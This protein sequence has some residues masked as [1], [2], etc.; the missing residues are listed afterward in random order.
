M[1][2]STFFAA[3]FFL[4]L[5]LNK[6]NKNL[7][8]VLQLFSVVGTFASNSQ[9]HVTN[10]TYIC[11]SLHV[12]FAR[13]VPVPVHAFRELVLFSLN[14]PGKGGGSHANKEG[15]SSY[16]LGVE[17]PGFGTAYGVQSKV[18][19]FTQNGVSPKR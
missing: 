6:K 17:I 3:L 12:C 14:V 4:F 5:H 13:V 15:C 11:T 19:A 18:R 7:A 9:K 8:V 10:S 16:L 2:S 1:S